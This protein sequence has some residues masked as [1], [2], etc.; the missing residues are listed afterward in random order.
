[1][2]KYEMPLV[3]YALNVCVQLI[4]SFAAFIKFYKITKSTVIIYIRASIKAAWLCYPQCGT[5]VGYVGVSG[6]AFPQ[7]SRR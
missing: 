7:I 6:N 2:N 4:V 5:V 1:M 3:V